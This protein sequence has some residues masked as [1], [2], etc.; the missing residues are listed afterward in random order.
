MEPDATYFLTATILHWQP[1]LGHDAVKDILIQEWRHR[2]QLGHLKIYGFVIMPNHYHMILT[3]PSPHKPEDI[4]RDIH[5][6]TS[7]K[8]IQWLKEGHD[9][10]A[11]CRVDAADRAYQIWE[12]NSLPVRLYTPAVFQQKLDYI[13]NN[14]LQ[15]HWQLAAVPEDY[16]Y[17]SA[18]YYLCNEEVWDFITHFSE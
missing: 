8:M 11:S 6:W 5:K 2:V 1:L 18:R 4:L 15:A 16:H 7:R 12:R 13:H 14:P 9:L 17:S 10:L 3:I